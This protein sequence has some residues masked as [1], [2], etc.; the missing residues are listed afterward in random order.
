MRTRVLIYILYHLSIST[1]GDLDHIPISISSGQKPSAAFCGRSF[2]RP[3]PPSQQLLA[4]PIFRRHG[5]HRRSVVVGHCRVSWSP[6]GI[7]DGNG[8]PPPICTSTIKFFK[9]TQC[10]EKEFNRAASREYVL[11]L[12]VC[13]GRYAC[14][15][16][17]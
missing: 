3:N 8:T 11:V 15:T 9:L 1:M 16:P 5:P 17:V 6:A 10:W 12:S 4:A 2:P 14:P 7:A 13:F